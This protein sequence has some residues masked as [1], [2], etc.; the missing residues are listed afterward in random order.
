MGIEQIDLHIRN[1]IFGSGLRQ[2]KLCRIQLLTQY[3]DLARMV[4]RNITFRDGVSIQT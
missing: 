1:V 3:V 4:P 2:F